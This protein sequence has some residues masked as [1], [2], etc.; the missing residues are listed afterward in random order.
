MLTC[1]LSELVQSIEAASVPKWLH[2][3]VQD[4]R[5]AIVDGLTRFGE[6]TIPIPSGSQI[7]IRQE[8]PTPA[9]RIMRPNCF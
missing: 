8:P 6:Y 9:K 1:R 7:V 3:Y 2:E 5:E 4:N